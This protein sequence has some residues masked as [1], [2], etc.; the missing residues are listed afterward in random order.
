MEEVIYLPVSLQYQ[1]IGNNIMLIVGQ[2]K[3]KIFRL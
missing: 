3:Y 1:F 2:E